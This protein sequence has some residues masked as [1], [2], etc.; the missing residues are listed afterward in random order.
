MLLV[1]SSGCIPDLLVKWIY[2]PFALGTNSEGKFEEH[3]TNGIV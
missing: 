1:N 2:F 3:S